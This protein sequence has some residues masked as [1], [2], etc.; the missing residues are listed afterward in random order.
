MLMAGPASRDV[1]NQ[2]LMNQ[3]LVNRNLVNRD[4]PAKEALDR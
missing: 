4:S 3:H 2:D 1:L